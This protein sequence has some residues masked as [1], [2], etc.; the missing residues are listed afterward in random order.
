MSKNTVEIWDSVAVYL[1]VRGNRVTEHKTYIVA[2]PEGTITFGTPGSTVT[3]EHI[4]SCFSEQYGYNPEEFLLYA[5][6]GKNKK[7]IK[8]TLSNMRKAAH[9]IR[10]QAEE[11]ALK[12]GATLRGPREDTERLKLTENF[13][14]NLDIEF[15]HNKV[16]GG[17]KAKGK[18]KELT[19]LGKTSEAPTS[20]VKA[21]L[22]RVNAPGDV[23]TKY[24]YISRFTCPE[25][26]SLCPITG[27]PDFA[28][29]II[30]YVP[31]DWCVESKS[32]KLFMF[33]FRDHQDF[34]EACTY[35]IG[36]RLHE[37]LDPKWIAVTAFWNPRGG[38]PIDIFWMRGELPDHLIYTQPRAADY[39]VRS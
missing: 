34:H 30:D 24:D 28:T 11:R 1:A 26:T 14:K 2:P 17:K 31:N 29:V 3:E 9:S 5:L 22:D 27:Q 20:P 21:V 15:Y 35:Y 19:H 38:I 32:L 12:R 25:V 18:K 13:I 37:L 8:L 10:R 23:G 6:K 33:S 39:R 16:K 36:E 7:S 4:V